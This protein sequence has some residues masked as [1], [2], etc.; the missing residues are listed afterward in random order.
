MEIN[1]IYRITVTDVNEDGAGFCRID[2][3]A[4]FVPGLLAGESAEVRIVSA[5]KNYAI[6]ECVRRL[7]DSP[8]RITPVCPSSEVCGGCTLAHV[9]FEEENRIKQNSVKSAFRRA[10]LPFGLVE[11]TVHGE[12]RCGYRNKL[13]V[14]ASDDGFGLY[15]HG[16]NDVVPFAGCAIC[17]DVM[18]RI[19]QFTNE[20]R[21]LLP[22]C[23][24]IFV[25]TVSGGDV[26]VSADCAGNLTGYRNALKNAFPEVRDVVSTRGANGVIRDEMGGITM[27][28]ST[29]AFRQ[30]NAEA[31]AL[32]L[33]LVHGMAGAKSFRYAADL[34]CGSGIIGLTLAKRFPG[35]KFYGIE[36]NSD[37][38]RDA[39]A[40]AASN[41]IGNIRFFCGDAA[42]FKEKIPKKELPELVVVDPP[43]AGLSNPM[44]KGLLT[45]RADTVIYVSCNP[46]TLARDVKSLSDEYDVKRI[47]P[48]NMFPM[49]R[50]CECVVLLERKNEKLRRFLANARLLAEMHITPLL[51]GSLGLELLTHEPLGADDIDILIPE[52]FLTERWD[53][54]CGMLEKN[55]CT[56]TDAH[57]HTF[58][59]DGVEYSYAKIEELE[60]FAGISTADIA[61]TEMDRTKFGLLSLEQYLAVYRASSQDGYRIHTRQKKDFDKIALIERKLRENDAKSAPERK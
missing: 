24:G 44:R 37:A 25:R 55:G 27:E 5:E 60:A 21:H 23:G 15:R 43:R 49:T 31:F 8:E 4:V 40:N 59:K 58:T 53:E 6:G 1:G 33:E 13:G 51:Y 45:L 46:Q 61:E 19:V 16:T 48:V 9:T 12:K 14:H 22:D 32:L 54:F 26:T 29:E 20:N 56:L 7:N 41:G 36:I 34:Y 28:F 17:P 3:M 39:K 35:A 47:V 18:S 11:E 2:G 52:V 50:H 57:E 30:V 42:S 10:G 38:I